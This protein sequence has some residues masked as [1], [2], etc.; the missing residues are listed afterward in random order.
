MDEQHEK[1]S[2]VLDLGDPLK[3]RSDSVGEHILY[4][5]QQIQTTLNLRDS[6]ETE[7]VSVLT[8]LGRKRNAN[9]SLSQN[10]PDATEDTQPKKKRDSNV[11]LFQNDTEM[12]YFHKGN[13][14]GMTA[15]NVVNILIEKQ[16]VT[17]RKRPFSCK[18]NAVFLVELSSKCLFEDITFDDMTWLSSGKRKYSLTINKNGVQILPKHSSTNYVLIRMYRKNKSNENFRCII[19]YINDRE[20]ILNNQVLIQY[21]FIGQPSSFSVK[22]HGNSKNVTS[23]KP[24]KPS[25]KR[26]LKELLRVKP[27]AEAVREVRRIVEGGEKTKNACGDLPLGKQQAYDMNR[28]KKK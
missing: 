19:S 7:A 16:H 15:L 14:R 6:A 17:C 26:L 27:P 23:F 20:V 13:C 25:T 18:E 21:Y 12:P 1:D 4:S 22:P 2:A 28:R 9:V 8:S 11:S 3:K 10:S 24:T 5:G